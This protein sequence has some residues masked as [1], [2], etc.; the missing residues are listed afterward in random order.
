MRR[1]LRRQF[2]DAFTKCQVL[3]SPVTT[4]AAFKIGERITDPL[5]MYMNDI[6]TTSANLV[7][8]PGISVPAGLTGDGLPVGVQLLSSHFQEQHLFNVGSVIEDVIVGNDLLFPFQVALNSHA[9]KLY[10]TYFLFEDGA[11]DRANLD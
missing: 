3:L 11:I 8:I 2:Q 5:Q 10:W 6:F 7:G 4:T 1:L 9:G